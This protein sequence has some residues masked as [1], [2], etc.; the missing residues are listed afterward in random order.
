MHTDSDPPIPA[1][2]QESLHPL[3]DCVQAN[4][5]SL[6]FRFKLLSVSALRELGVEVIAAGDGSDREL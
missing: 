4:K 3:H 2:G 5:P 1:I 6:Q